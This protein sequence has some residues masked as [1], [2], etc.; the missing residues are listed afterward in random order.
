MLQNNGHLVLLITIFVLCIGTETKEFG[1]L[2]F[3]GK[4][5]LIGLLNDLQDNDSKGS[6]A[7]YSL[8]SELH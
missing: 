1:K 4:Y 5:L 3:L 8:S 7:Y 2:P 6:Q